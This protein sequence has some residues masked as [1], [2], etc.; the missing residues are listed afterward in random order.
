MSPA[1]SKVQQRAAGLALSAKRGKIPKSSLK[2]AAKEMMDM[3]MMDLKHMASTPVKK[4]PKRVK[5]K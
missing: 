5:K 2:G 1:K 3:S 4:L